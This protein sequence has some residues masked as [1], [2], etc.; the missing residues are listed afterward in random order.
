MIMHQNLPAS[1]CNFTGSDVL[2]IRIS[3]KFDVDLCVTFLNFQAGSIWE[4]LVN[5]IT[6][7]KLPVSSCNLI[8]VFSTSKSFTG[9]MLTFVPTFLNFQTWS[10]SGGFV[11]MLNLPASF[12]SF[13]GSYVLLIRI[14]A[15]LDVDLCVTFLNFLVDSISS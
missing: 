7:H 9:L 11:N 6:F 2:L 5:V 1:C 8:V 10:R 13:T 4:D 15:K 12:C 14:S 3:T